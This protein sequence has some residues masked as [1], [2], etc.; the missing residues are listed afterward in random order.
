MRNS[1][2]IRGIRDDNKNRRGQTEGGESGRSFWSKKMEINVYNCYIVF[3]CNRKVSTS[4]DPV[5]ATLS[6]SMCLAMAAPADG[7]IPGRTFTTPSGNPT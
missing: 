6:T 1:L 2:I 7:P 4:V 3:L 5:N